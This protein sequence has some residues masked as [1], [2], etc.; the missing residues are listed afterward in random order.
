VLRG[1]SVYRAGRLSYEVRGLRVTPLSDLFHFLMR[2][3]WSKL[4][5]SFVL[6]Y[7]GVNALFAGLYWLGGEGTVLNAR[8]GAFADDFWFSVQTFATIGYGVLSP[9]STY[10]HALVTLE[11]FCGMLAV[12][13][14]TGIV[15][16]KFSL[17][18]A[19]VAFSRNLIVSSRN[20]QPCLVC[21]VANRRISSLLDA[22]A[23][24]H[25]LMDEISSEGHRMRRNHAL[26]LERSSMPVFLL[27]WTLIHRLDESSPLYGLCVENAEQRLVGIIV[28]FTGVD[29]TMLQ[30]VHARQLYSA[31]DL[32]FGA[33]FADMIDASTP[34]TLIIDHAQLDEL[35]PEAAPG[36][37]EPAR[38]RE[39]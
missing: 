17:P 31:E 12:A 28:S 3:A 39:P 25:V 14:S 30:A 35:L 8:P 20:G 19:R 26:Q 9:G 23:Q 24:A 7:C 10:G 18:K 32:R 38:S 2:T 37:S 22:S 11:S 36:A 15:F 27:A 29:E 33:R 5:A 1:P 16:A 6:I 34:G 13:L 4:L 21:R